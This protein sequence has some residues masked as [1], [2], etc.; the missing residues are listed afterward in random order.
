MR[1]II[2]KSGGYLDK[3]IERILH[4]NNINGD[5]AE[6]L[7]RHAINQYDCIIFT[8]QND[9]PNL[10]KVIEQ[11][12]LEK[13]NIVIL[14]NNTFSIG[15]YYNIFDDLHFSMVNEA[16]LDFELPFIIKNNVKFLR[17]IKRITDEK[18]NL[19]N[20]LILLKNTNKAKRILMKKGLNEAESHKFIQQKAMAL[21]VSKEKLVNLIIENKIDI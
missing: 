16:T 2:V 15:H 20:E 8:Y 14:V 9:I 10:P 17:S 21:R 7:T 5:I 11:V 6:K 13:K 3:R 4:Q 19:Y 1:A 12:V 18:K